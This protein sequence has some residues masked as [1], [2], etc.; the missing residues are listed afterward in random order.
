[1]ATTTTPVPSNPK[2]INFLTLF[3]TIAINA[4]A[5]AATVASDVE[6]G[7]KTQAV[8]AAITGAANSLSQVNPAWSV[9]IAAA[10]ATAQLGVSIISAFISL[11]HHP[12]PATPAS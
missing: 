3:N 11:F 4:A 2:F 7:E 1:M 10:S 12:K 5:G 6:A 9:D 8:S